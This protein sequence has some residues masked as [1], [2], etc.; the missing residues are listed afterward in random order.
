MGDLDFSEKNFAQTAQIKHGNSNIR[1]SIAPTFLGEKITLRVLSAKSRV[2]TLE[3]I[4]IWG[5]NL[6]L[7]QQALR[8]PHGI[9]FTIGQGKNNTNFALIN[10]LVSSEKN[11]V[12]VEK[13][14]EKAI[15]NLN[16]TSVN[17][18][19]GLD[20]FR[21]TQSSLNQNPDVIMVDDVRDS[22][23]AELLFD[24]AARGKLVVASV[25]V[26]HISEV[27]PYLEFLGTPNFLLA[28]NILAV[29]SQK[30]VR[31]AAKTALEFRKINKTESQV[32]ANEFKVQIPVIHELE[33]AAAKHFGEK[34]HTSELSILEIPQMKSE[35][36]EIGFTGVTGIFEVMSFI[37]GKFGRELRNLVAHSPNS[38][39]IEDFLDENNF[40]SLK[41]DGLLKAL[42]GQTTV[43]EIM[44]R[45]GF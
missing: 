32:L 14:I 26:Q 3:E 7:I 11:I 38:A 27:I 36:S 44:R 16:Q 18:R 31:T 22:K 4:G 25:P 41:T 28:T 2:R 8:Q 29:V 33:K 12:T 21:A 37:D 5:E 17:P 6:R 43:R 13:H 42:Q 30:L 35:F 9:I 20:Y 19:I 10:E 45:T 15:P 34:T 24:A 39:E 23:T 40:V 1:V